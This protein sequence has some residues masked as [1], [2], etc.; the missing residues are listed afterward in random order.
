MSAW[1]RIF[2]VQGSTGLLKHDI[3]EDNQNENDITFWIDKHNRYAVSQPLKSCTVGVPK[4]NGVL[5]QSSLELPI[6]ALSFCE[7]F[8]IANLPLYVRPFL[9]FST[10]IFSASVSLM[11][12][13]V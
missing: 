8:G 12:K 10:A 13:R 5:G 9:L 7:E 2:I 1:I 6:S 11:E 4:W 3:I